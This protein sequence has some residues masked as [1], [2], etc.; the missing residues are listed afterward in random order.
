MCF[1]ELCFCCFEEKTTFYNL[2]MNLC[3][4][5]IFFVL[6]SYLSPHRS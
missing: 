5:Y 3:Y 4:T 6:N 2:L 1:V